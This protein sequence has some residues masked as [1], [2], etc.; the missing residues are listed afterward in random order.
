MLDAGWQ[1]PLPIVGILEKLRHRKSLNRIR[2]LLVFQVI[3]SSLTF[4]F[5]RGARFS[6]VIA[7]SNHQMRWH[8]ALSFSFSVHLVAGAC[9]SEGQ[10]VADHFVAIVDSLATLVIVLDG[11]VIA[12]VLQQHGL[13]D[14]VLCLKLIYLAHLVTVLDLAFASQVAAT[15]LVGALNHHFLRHLGRVPLFGELGLAWRGLVGDGHRR[16]LAKFRWHLH[17]AHQ[18]R[19][20]RSQL[21]DVVQIAR[22]ALTLLGLQLLAH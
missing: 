18:G 12:E 8:R 3:L 16:S 15:G 10:V 9:R 13:Q 1:V 2:R 11:A 5:R 4:L 7:A 20:S 17:G 22:C 14:V 6:G 19:R 21:R